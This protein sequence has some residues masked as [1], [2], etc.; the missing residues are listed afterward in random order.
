MMPVRRACGLALALLLGVAGATSAQGRNTL[1][2][3]DPEG[4]LLDPMTGE[5]HA[6]V[7]Y[8]DVTA[9]EVSLVDGRL[10]FAIEVAEPIP[11]A[12]P[13]GLSLLYGLMVDADGDSLPDYSADV[14]STDSGWVVSVYD[15]NRD[16]VA[17]QPGEPV[18]DGTVVS[19]EVDPNAL[20]TASPSTMLFRGRADGYKGPSPPDAADPF[21]L[22]FWTDSVP[23]EPLSWYRLGETAPLASDSVA[24]PAP[25]AGLR[26]CTTDP[27]GPEGL[28][29][30]DG[31][32][33]YAVTFSTF[34]DGAPSATYHV[35]TDR[36]PLKAVSIAT[37]VHEAQQA[38]P[39]FDIEVEDLG[40]EGE[41]QEP[42]PVY[43]DRDEY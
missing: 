29:S 13:D 1:L 36:G 32:H 25:A 33:L 4:D 16:E 42:D 8:S 37:S 19:A 24:S 20:G 30:G 12:L 41:V 2:M 17:A 34:R 21:A 10:R 7:G 6:G 26:W 40:R 15:I 9:V 3:H 28:P 31:H 22:D 18:V 14:G 38:W 27:C 23:N 39:V 11:A 35:Y 43:D 5:P